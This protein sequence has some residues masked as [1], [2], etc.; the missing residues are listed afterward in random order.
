MIDLFKMFPSSPHPYPPN[1]NTC[2]IKVF[3]NIHSPVTDIIPSPYLNNILFCKSGISAFNAKGMTITTFTYLVVTIVL[4]SSLKE[5]SWVKARWV[6][7]SVKAIKH[8]IELW[9]SKFFGKP[10]NILSLSLKSY[11]SVIGGGSAKWPKLAGVCFNFQS[12]YQIFDPEWRIGIFFI[13]N[14]YDTIKS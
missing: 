6:V 12:L 5:M 13:H 14:N 10:V 1:L 9:I 11:F 4:L 2:G 8:W 3:G 7:T